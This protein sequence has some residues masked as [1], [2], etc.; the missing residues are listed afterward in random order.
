MDNET[1]IRYFHMDGKM[2]GIEACFLNL[3]NKGFFRK[4]F[5]IFSNTRLLL[6]YKLTIK[7]NNL[8]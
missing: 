1:Q 5:I 3:N 7:L 6:L 8:Q 2:A 4:T